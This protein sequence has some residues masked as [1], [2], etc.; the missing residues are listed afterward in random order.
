MIVLENVW[1]LGNNFLV[2]GASEFSSDGTEHACAFWFFVGINDHTRIIIETN[3]AAIAPPSDCS[4]A[5][6]DCFLNRFLLYGTSRSC[7]FDCDDDDVAYVSIATLT[8]PEDFD[9][10]AGLGSCVICHVEDALCLNHDTGVETADASI[11]R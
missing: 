9:A 2:A 1:S 10:H 11:S 7:F 5:D 8:A 4:G 6:N 3:A